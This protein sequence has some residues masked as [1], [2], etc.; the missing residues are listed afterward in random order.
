MAFKKQLTIVILTILITSCKTS[1][2][3]IIEPI[4][5][6]ELMLQT[7]LS[8]YT[9]TQPLGI[10]N[11]SDGSNRLFI[12]EK[13]GSIKVVDLQQEEVNTFLNIS[14][15]VNA[16][17][18]MGLLGLAFHP[19]YV[20]NGYF[21]INYNTLDN[22][23]RI[24]RFSVSNNNSNLADLNSEQVLMEFPQEQTNHNGGQL[25]FGSDGFLYISSGDGGDWDNPQNLSSLKGAILRID[26]DNVSNGL[27]YSIPADN[28]FINEPSASGEIYAYGLRNP[29]RISFD[30]QTGKLW[31]A[32]VGAGDWEEINI[33][34]SSNNYGWPMYEANSCYRGPC[35]NNGL[36]FPIFEYSH[37]I[38]RSITGGYVYRGN[39]NIELIE[40]YVYGDFNT[41][42]IWALNIETFE[43]ELLF[44]TD[45]QITSFG[46]D[47]NNELYVCDIAGK[48]HKFVQIE[49]P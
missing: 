14:Q 40:K 44:D 24:S 49:I 30:E 32:D 28:P 4:V 10:E 48:I 34:E 25:A 45:L 27:N 29:W 43:N 16:T 6:N 9:F 31:A 19:N 3:A 21:Y 11:S 23:T 13:Q 47:E 26:V 22:L 12:V 2:D 18:E 7:L 8:D 41:G 42:K 38:G 17:N 46:L 1:D 37:D 36:T 20:S 35:Q 39:E 5:N 15:V 33:I